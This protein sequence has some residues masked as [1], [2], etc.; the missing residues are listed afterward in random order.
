MEETKSVCGRLEDSRMA[1]EKLTATDDD[2][3]Q[4]VAGLLCQFGATRVR[5]SILK[6]TSRGPG[7]PMKGKDDTILALIAIAM[8]DG[9]L[10]RGEAVRKVAGL[11]ATDGEYRRLFTASR[12]LESET[13]S[14]IAMLRPANSL[15]GFPEPIFDFDELSRRAKAQFQAQ[16]PDVTEIWVLR[17]I[18]K[19]ED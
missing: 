14:F 3:D 15:E 13:Q 9:G 1:V 7:A 5:N 6:K 10:G 18:I 12:R 2:V 19:I 8:R 4:A 11:K 16:F 17:N